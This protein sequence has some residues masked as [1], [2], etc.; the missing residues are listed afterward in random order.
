[1]RTLSEG[2]I[3]ERAPLLPLRSFGNTWNI[4]KCERNP[5]SVMGQFHV[6]GEGI[7]CGLVVQK[8]RNMREVGATWLHGLDHFKTLFHRKVG[9]VRPFTEGIENENVEVFE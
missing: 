2:K 3:N 4:G 8:M 9:G 6:V 1:M 7:T 5:Q